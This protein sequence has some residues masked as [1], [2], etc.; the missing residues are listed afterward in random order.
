MRRS[1]LASIGVVVAL[2]AAIGVYRFAVGEWP[3]QRT[4]AAYVIG[5]RSVA[6]DTSYVAGREKVW[7]TIGEPQLLIIAGYEM[8]VMVEPVSP[9][10][11][12]LTI[13]IDYDLPRAS[14]MRL[15]GLALAG[16]YSRVALVDPVIEAVRQQRR[17]LALGP[18]N[19]PLHRLPPQIARRIISAT[20]FSRTQGQNGSRADQAFPVLGG[21]LGQHE[22][23]AQGFLGFGC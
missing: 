15:L 22:Q 20:A 14:V 12:L 17:L 19:E 5:E 3:G 11:S 21:K 8:R 13:G 4:I 6:A 9:R 23:L 1:L 18:F 7:R 16:A 10:S 2:S